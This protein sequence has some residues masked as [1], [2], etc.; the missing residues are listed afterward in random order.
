ML[1]FS[2]LYWISG[3]A[4][5]ISTTLRG[6]TRVI[7]TQSF[8]AELML[9]VVERYKVT[10]TMMAPSHVSTLLQSPDIHIADLSSLRRFYATGSVVSEELCKRINQFLPSEL[11]V[12]Y[13]MSEVAGMLASN[14]IPTR[15]GSVGLLISGMRM[16]VL[17]DEN[18]LCGPNE[19]GEISIWIDPPFQGYWNNE[20]ATAAMIDDDGWLR[21][22]D[23]GHFDDDGYLYL[24]DR[25][26][27][28]MKYRN[29]QISPSELEGVVLGA[30]GVAAVCVVGVPDGES[31]DLATALVVRSKDEEIVTE[32]EIY[33]L[34]R[35]KLI[36]YFEVYITI[37]LRFICFR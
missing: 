17:D 12:V 26:K 27:D 2:S 32:E 18:G 19:D 28:M 35:G 11:L 22:G 29:Y 1:T 4:A 9:E 21:S 23:V 25:K 7:T 34:V 10:V 30:R 24:V 14:V 37:K 31:N 16:R 36:N 33:D 3:F 13:G 15:S 20:E 5:L 6:A 8:N